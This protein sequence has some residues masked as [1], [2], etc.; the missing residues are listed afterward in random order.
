MVHFLVLFTLTTQGR[1]NPANAAA[2]LTGM[3]KVLQE[4]G[5]KVDKLM[6]TYGQY[7]AALAGECPDHN[8][9]TGFLAWVHDQ[10]FFSTQT[11]IGAD[12]T[13]YKPALHHS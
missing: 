7:D 9:L 6:M 5:G 2:N 8:A 13:A 12:G 1:G 11:L 4:L 3:G 10:G